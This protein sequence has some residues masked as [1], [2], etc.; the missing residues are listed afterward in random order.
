MR[1]AAPT[2]RWSTHRRT[3]AGPRR[4]PPATT[5]GRASSPY[6]CGS[7]RTSPEGP[8]TRT[9]IAVP[10]RVLEVA[11]VR[12]REVGA[13]RRARVDPCSGAGAFVGV[14]FAGGSGTT[15]LNYLGVGFAGGCRRAGCAPAAGA[16][17]SVRSPGRRRDRRVTLENVPLVDVLAG[18]VTCSRVIRRSCGPGR[19]ESGWGGNRDRARDGPE[20]ALAGTTT[21]PRTG[22]PRRPGPGPAPGRPGAGLRLVE[23]GLARSRPGQ[24][25]K[26]LDVVFF[27][28]GGDGGPGRGGSGLRNSS[29]A[30]RDPGAGARMGRDRLAQCEPSATQSTP[31]RAVRAQH[32]EIR[33]SSIRASPPRTMRPE[34]TSPN[35][36]PQGAG[37]RPR[38]RD[39]RDAVGRLPPGAETR[40]RTAPRV[41]DR[42]SGPGAGRAGAS[43]RRAQ[44]WAPRWVQWSRRNGGCR[45]GRRGPGRFPAPARRGF[46]GPPRLVG[47]WARSALLA[48]QVPRAA[49]A[50]PDTE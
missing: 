30:Q 44:W 46:L 33:P 21:D 3:R 16:A 6:P 15:K 7:S 47:R 20:S 10:V 17:R 11:A 49:R 5:S 35:R 34:V 18:Q 25:V 4:P 40:R 8:G 39:G 50:S 32:D 2:A 31:P 43:A 22:T 48:P 12:R 37:A 19:D 1:A 26:S 42:V 29:S 23:T 28:S 13:R 24:R 9:L 14:G 38:L 41:P 36:L 27:R 45:G